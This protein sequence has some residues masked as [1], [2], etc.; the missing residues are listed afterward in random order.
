MTVYAQ[1]GEGGVWL[2]REKGRKTVLIDKDSPLS[3]EIDIGSMV[4]GYVSHED[5]RKVILTPTKI[6]PP[7]I[8]EVQAVRGR[9]DSI[10][11]WA[12]DGRAVL[13][14]SDAPKTSEVEV[15]D[16]V[17]GRVTREAETYFWLWPEEVV[18]G[19]REVE[20]VPGKP[21]HPFCPLILNELVSVSRGTVREEVL[22]IRTP[23]QA[24]EDLVYGAFE[25]LQSGRVTQLGYRVGGQPAPDGDMFC[26]ERERAQYVVLWDAKSR[27]GAPGYIMSVTDK[28]AFESY[29]RDGKYSPVRE[30]ALVVVS[31]SFADAPER[32]S[33]G[34]LTFLTSKA[35]GLICAW[36]AMNPVL[37][38]HKT[39]KNLLFSGTI[40]T[41]DEV[42]EWARELRLR[43]IPA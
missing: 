18:P 10:I 43:E 37:V 38:D 28:R 4:T 12:A 23:D 31:S 42:K 39:L 5:E 21:I 19:K 33:E 34:V 35:L 26:P 36:K 25:F 16:L 22:G 2:Y 13:F 30:R 3:A 24:F 41:D 29:L 14:Q 20:I 9:D 11:G 27:A 7:E 32:L 1:P 6:E 8:L 17:R 15:G 40:V